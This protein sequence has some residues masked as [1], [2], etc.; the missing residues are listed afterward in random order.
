MASQAHIRCEVLRT[1]LLRGTEQTYL[2]LYM[3][4]AAGGEELRAEEGPGWMRKESTR[5]EASRAMLS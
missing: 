2:R 5:E 1:R 3:T 4:E